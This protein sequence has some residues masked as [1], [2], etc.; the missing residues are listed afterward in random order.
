MLDSVIKTGKKILSSNV[1]RRVQIQDY[2]EENG[3]SYH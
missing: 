2:K 3:K 1:S